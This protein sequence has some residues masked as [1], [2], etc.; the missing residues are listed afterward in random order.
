MAPWPRSEIYDLIE[1]ERLRQNQ[2]KADGRFRFTCA[3]KVLPN[4][5]KLAIIGEEFGEVCRALIEQQGLANDLH[6]AELKK[7]L[8]HVAAVAVA[9]LE[10]LS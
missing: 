1:T 8:I 2:L 3:D 10:S 7:E 9:W 6:H 4:E 5:R